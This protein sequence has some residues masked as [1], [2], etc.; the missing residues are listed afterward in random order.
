MPHEWL[1]A[2]IL[3]LT[4]ACEFKIKVHAFRLQSPVVCLRITQSVL[5]LPVIV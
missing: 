4:A 2:H 5:V 3:K 1:C